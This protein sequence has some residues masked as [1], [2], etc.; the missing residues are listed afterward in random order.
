MGNLPNL[1]INSLIVLPFGIVGFAVLIFVGNW[2]ND[3]FVGR[4]ERATLEK[5]HRTMATSLPAIEPRERKTTDPCDPPTNPRVV[6]VAV[7]L[8]DDQVLTLSDEDF[9]EITSKIKYRREFLDTIKTSE[10]W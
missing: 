6:P 9:E 2:I 8:T 10:G 1:E 7:V 5:W 4:R 3:A